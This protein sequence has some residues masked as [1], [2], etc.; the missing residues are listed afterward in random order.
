MPMMVKNCSCY[1]L[2]RAVNQKPD[3]QLEWPFI[4]MHVLTN[5]SYS[6]ITSYWYTQRDVSY[7]EANEQSSSI[8]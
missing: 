5:Y 6:Y 1:N 4:Y 3:N 7:T 8:Q 2:M